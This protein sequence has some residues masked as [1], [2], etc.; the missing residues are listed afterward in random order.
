MV[1]EHKSKMERDKTV[2]RRR[3][4]ETNLQEENEDI[5]VKER[6][7][8]KIDQTCTK[9]II[10][11]SGVVCILSVLLMYCP[12]S[13]ITALTHKTID[14][15]LMHAGIS[16]IIYAVVLGEY[17]TRFLVYHFFKNSCVVK[18]LKLNYIF[19]FC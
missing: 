9:L 16:P 4:L 2:R 17:S 13:T 11:L 6:R 7:S 18:S 8:S 12:D 5:A 14:Y 10:L 19:I 1:S 15:V 3:K